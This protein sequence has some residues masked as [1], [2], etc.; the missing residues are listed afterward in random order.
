MKILLSTISFAGLT[1]II[2]PACL[3][4]AG[5]TAKPQ[6]QTL[7]FVGTLLW[8]VT[9]PLWMGKTDRSP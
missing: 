3:Y 1:L 7:M 8:F 6:M 2:V 5:F 4:L 9:A